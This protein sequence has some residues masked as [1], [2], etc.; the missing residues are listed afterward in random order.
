M[1]WVRRQSRMRLGRISNTRPPD[2]NLYTSAGSQICVH[3][4]RYKQFSK[5][6]VPVWLPWARLLVLPMQLAYASLILMSGPFPRRL[7]V[8]G[9]VFSPWYLTGHLEILVRSACSILLPV[10][11]SSCL[12]KNTGLYILDRNLL[13]EIFIASIGH[14]SLASLFSLLVGVLWWLVLNFNVA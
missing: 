3:Y 6:P 12:F 11:L 2:I 7:T 4:G 14:Y 1:G 10:F 5:M 8:L 13:L 9:H